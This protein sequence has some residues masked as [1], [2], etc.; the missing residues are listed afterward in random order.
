MLSDNLNVAVF[1]RFFMHSF[2]LDVISPLR[3]FV[4]PPLCLVFK[5]GRSDR[6]SLYLIHSGQVRLIQG[7]Q[8]QAVSSH[9]NNMVIFLFS[10][11]YI[12]FFTNTNQAIFLVRIEDYF[13]SNLKH[14]FKEYKTVSTHPAHLLAALLSDT[15]DSFGFRNQFMSF[16]KRV[17][18]SYNS[19][20]SDYVKDELWVR[21]KSA[22]EEVMK[23]THYREM[24]P[25]FF[26]KNKKLYDK[27]SQQ[28]VVGKGSVLPNLNTNLKI[29]YDCSCG[30][31]Y[32]ILTDFLDHFESH[33]FRH[34]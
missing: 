12:D 30:N 13:I 32:E 6:W 31:Q 34:P 14:L 27:F 25:A 5:E 7:L 2:H 21:N 3:L 10:N 23:S 9:I 8:F 29:Y 33:T 22:F 16:Y 4:K 28:L 20:W 17:V 15:L 11:E 19:G 26:P 18:F 24:C 1:L